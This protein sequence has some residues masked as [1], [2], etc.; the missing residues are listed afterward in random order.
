MATAAD[1]SEFVISRTFDAPRELVF[2]AWTEPAHLA[3]WWGPKEMDA[4][5]QMDA[6]AGGEFRWVMIDGRAGVEYPIRGRFLEVSPPSRLVYRHDLS[7]HPESWHDLVSPGRDRSKPPP[8]NAATVTVTFEETDG[9]TTMTVH[10]RFDSA[11]DAAAHVKLGMGGGWAMSFDKL[12]AM[13]PTADRELVVTRVLD[14]PREL[15]WKAWTTPEHIAQWW[16]PRGFTNT[17]ETMDVRPGGAWKFVM[18]GPDGTNYPN[19]SVFVEVVR[20]ERIVFDHIAPNFRATATFTELGGR[21]RLE[22]KMLFAQAKDLQLVV[23]RHGADEGL[24]QNVDKLA[25]YLKAMSA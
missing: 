4:R 6:H 9:R 24:R 22:W 20:P 12:A 25:E 10:M 8:A 13:L 11:V 15:V 17:I 5:I 18:H 19:H 1:P 14:A 7:E 2:R 21:T 23:K 3:R 16:G